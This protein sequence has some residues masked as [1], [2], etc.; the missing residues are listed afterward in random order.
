VG[1]EEC[2]SASVP[3]ASQRP[4]LVIFVSD[5]AMVAALLVV[6]PLDCGE[7]RERDV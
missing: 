5:R 7:L 2:S 3:R 1:G 4:A 6:A